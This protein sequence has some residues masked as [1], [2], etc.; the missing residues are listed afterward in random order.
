VLDD[1]AAAPPP[2]DAAA[3]PP[4]ADAT[5][6]PPPADAAA[7]P[8]AARFPLSED[9]VATALAAAPEGTVFHI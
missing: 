7:H 2:A 6:A 8:P 5:A 9:A 3:A 1:A 4:L